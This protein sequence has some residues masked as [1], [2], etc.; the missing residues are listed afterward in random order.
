MHMLILTKPFIPMYDILYDFWFDLSQLF[1]QLY[2]LFFEQSHLD[3][4]LCFFVEMLN[5]NLSCF[6]T[7]FVLFAM[8][9]DMFN[10][11]TILFD[12]ICQI[13]IS[14]IFL[15]KWK[16]YL[17]RFFLNH[18]IREQ[19]GGEKRGLQISLIS[20][21]GNIT[22]LAIWSLFFEV[23][24]PRMLNFPRDDRSDQFQII[25]F[26]DGFHIRNNFWKHHF[27]LKL[28]QNLFCSPLA[29]FLF[30]L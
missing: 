16:H 21:D 27:S 22:W 10:L 23:W 24:S 9:L 3:F 2:L 11:L 18:V 8:H 20:I 13:L 15:Q 26:L 4:F 19:T 30:V 14:V 12:F 17:L 6:L 29:V 28:C 1:L 7:L 25:S 5:N